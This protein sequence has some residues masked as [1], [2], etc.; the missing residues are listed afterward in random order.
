ML[1]SKIFIFAVAVAPPGAPCSGPLTRERVI[2][3]ATEASPR[4]RADRERI[5]V[6]RA[7]TEAARVML[8]SN[9]KVAVTVGQRW[10]TVG[11]RALNVGGTLSQELEIA[12]QRRK[13]QASAR[14]TE[15]AREHAAVAT[16]RD[17]VAGALLAYYDVLAARQEVEVVQR[18]RE[19]AQRLHDVADA[20]AAAGLGAP[21]EVELAGAEAARLTERT[22]LAEGRLRVSKVRLASQL[23][24]DPTGD[25]PE[26]RGALVAPSA[27]ENLR[28][29]GELARSRPELAS[30]RATRR[31]RS[32]RLTVLRR[33]RVPSPTLSFFAQ[34]DGFN[35]RVIGGGISF[36]IPMPF[37]LGRTNKGEIQ[38]TQA[39]LRETDERIAAQER[40]LTLDAAVAYHELK[41]RQDAAAAYSESAEARARTSL[42]DLSSEIEAGRLLV[43]DALVTQQGLIAL[44]LRA[45]EARHQACRASVALTVAAGIPFEEDRS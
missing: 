13:R 2:E 38:A 39:E 22:A 5:A 31:S 29:I 42:E 43:R 18:A 17:V 20:R 11:D 7:E 6:A 8:P 9:P 27:G 32:E 45:V 26:V 15:T 24:L 14:A 19:T 3:C 10:N 4:L 30:H 16:E 37:P 25:L 12:G 33:E 44:L 23:G 34:T 36:P 28:R 40:A 21:I 35:E 41:A 1:L